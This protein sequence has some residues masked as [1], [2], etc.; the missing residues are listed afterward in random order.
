MSDKCTGQ[1]VALLRQ[2]LD[3]L[4]SNNSQE[5]FPKPMQQSVTRQKLLW[6]KEKDGVTTFKD[7]AAV[8]PTHHVLGVA[9]HRTAVLPVYSR[10]PP[11]LQ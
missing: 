11:C 1:L 7:L 10:Q 4:W 9:A 8:M 5:A 2:V 3:A 6:A